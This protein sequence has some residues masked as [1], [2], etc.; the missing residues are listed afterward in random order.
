MTHQ[1]ILRDFPLAVSLIEAEEGFRVTPYKCT[2]GKTTIGFGTNAEAHG[3]DVTGQVWTRAQAE[4]ALL[5][6]LEII[7]A[8]LDRRWPSWRAL[9]DIRV[10]VI[11][12]SVYQLGIYGAA[13]FKATIAALLER[14]FNA[15]A[16]RL[17]ASRWAKQT[18]ARVKRNAEAIRTGKLPEVVNGVRI[19]PE[20]VGADDTSA[21]AQS[22]APL[23]PP[24]PVDEQK[25]GAEVGGQ[26]GTILQ[27]DRFVISK[28]LCVLAGACAFVMFGPQ[29]GLHLDSEQ[30][31]TVQDMVMTYLGGQSAVDALKPFV[32]QLS[33]LFASKPLNGK[34]NA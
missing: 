10:A 1:D 5:D 15:A 17:L 20:G 12:S 32:P 11:L 4:A 30:L 26:V 3:L 24:V 21:L 34:H 29:L 6:E 18:P 33:A 16:E 27:S 19:F 9:D 7:I 14:D 13:Q 8:E 31:K 2:S 28:K 25:P 22:P 23:L